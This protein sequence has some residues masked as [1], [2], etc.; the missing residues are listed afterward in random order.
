MHVTVVTATAVASAVELASLAVV[1]H[2][3]WPSPTGRTPGGASVRASF[4]TEDAPAL[5]ENL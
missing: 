3:W 2:L 1:A 4:T 5:L